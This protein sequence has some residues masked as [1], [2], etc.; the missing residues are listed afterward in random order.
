MIEF[1]SLKELSSLLQGLVEGRLWAKVLIGLALGVGLGLAL[2]PAAGWVEPRVAATVTSWV[3]LPGGLF[4]RLV[5][6]IMVPLIVSSIVQGIAGGESVEQLRRMGPTVGI[7]FLVTTAIAVGVGLAAAL[8]IGPG[9]Q[10]DAGA[11]GGA[12]ADAPASAGATT[13]AA[14]AT[15][16]PDLRTLPE[17]LPRLL[18]SN[19]LASMVSGEMLSVV[20]FAVILGIALAAMKEETSAPVLR[21]ASSVQE[22][23]MTITRWAMKLAPFAVFGLIAQVTARVGVEAITGLALYVATVVAAL[24]VLVVLYALVLA[25]VARQ[26]LGAFARK[27]RDVLLLAFSV[28]SSAAVMPLSL[29]TVEEGFGVSPSIA[30]FVIPVGATINMNGTAAYQAVATIFLAQVYG[31]ELDAVDLILVVVTT[32]AASIG[33]P[34]APGAGVIVLGT[35]LGSVGVPIAGIALIIGVD[36]VLGMMRTAVNVMGDLTAAL[37]FDRRQPRSA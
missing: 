1:R 36:S 7:Y 24:V 10:F 16:P 31:L 23:C 26:P 30:R 33:T 14:G 17:L 3:A 18:P 32:V 5:Q 6:M 37:V 15:G 11:M 29:K 22:I 28:A 4:I 25:F 2:G 13:A 35:V 34:S 20:V 9:L 21:L 8:L 12:P 19:P 27:S